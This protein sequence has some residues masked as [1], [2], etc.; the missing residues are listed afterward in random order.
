MR[1]I[2]FRV[3]CVGISVQQIP[4]LRFNYVIA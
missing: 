3:F 2:F 1:E 4:I